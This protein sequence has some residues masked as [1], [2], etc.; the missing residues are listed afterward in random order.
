[1]AY[2]EK[3]NSK[4]MHK[5]QEGPSSEEVTD[6]LQCRQIQRTAFRRK[7]AECYSQDVSFQAI[8]SGTRKGSGSCWREVPE[9]ICP[10]CGWNHKKATNSKHGKKK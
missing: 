6:E 5:W 9:D 10:M 3:G 7:W 4:A 2:F 1:M 8:I